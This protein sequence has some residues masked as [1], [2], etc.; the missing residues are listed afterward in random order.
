M[1][2]SCLGLVAMLA[3]SLV[4]ASASAMGSAPVPPADAVGKFQCVASGQK[5][6]SGSSCDPARP[7][8][9]SPIGSTVHFYSEYF[10]R[11]ADA[12]HDAL[13]QCQSNGTV[14]RC[15]IVGCSQISSVN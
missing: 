11:E 5:R 6:D 1:S 7:T 12:R 8:C 2:N 4:S 13:R 14:W 10:A 9:N 3:T 15:Q